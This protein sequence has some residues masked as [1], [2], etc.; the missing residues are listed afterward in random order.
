[1]RSG[2]EFERQEEKHAQDLDRAKE[3]MLQAQLQYDKAKTEKEALELNSLK[4]SRDL[5]KAQA[6]LKEL[7]DLRGME[8]VRGAKEKAES[9]R[10]LRELED[11]HDR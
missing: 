6:E 2:H 5:E 7:R 10:I 3:K 4:L 9:E 8:D 1:M 11:L